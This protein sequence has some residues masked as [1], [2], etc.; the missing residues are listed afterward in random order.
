[1]LS[2]MLSELLL[3]LQ[4][5]PVAADALAQRIAAASVVLLAPASRDRLQLVRHQCCVWSIPQRVD[6]LRRPLKDLCDDLDAA[7][8]A[9]ATNLLDYFAL[10]VYHLG[11]WIKSVVKTIRTAV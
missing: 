4:T 3:Q 10:F 6:G 2:G 8:C 9:E 1:M 7:L 11:I 5:G